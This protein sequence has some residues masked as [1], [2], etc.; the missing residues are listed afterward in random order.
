MR[1]WW[2]STSPRACTRR[3][4]GPGDADTLLGMVIDRYPEVGGLPGMKPVE[5]GLVHRLDRDTS[6]CVVIA[7]TA[8]A[9]E[10]LREAFAS[11][12]ATKEYAAACACAP[13]APPAESLHIESRFAPY[14]EGRRRV[15][16]VLPR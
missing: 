13:G 5:P 9:F 12:R 8:R 10:T 4:C 6:G 15:R 3:P 2:S 16:V 7:R 1:A 11:G 14:G